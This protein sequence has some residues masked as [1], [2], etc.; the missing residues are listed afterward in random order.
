MYHHPPQ[1]KDDRIRT[2]KAPSFI[3]FSITGVNYLHSVLL[4]P[5]MFNLSYFLHV[6]LCSHALFDSTYGGKHV[7]VLSDTV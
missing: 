3:S 1:K 5:L 6:L 4:Q 7:F 2:R